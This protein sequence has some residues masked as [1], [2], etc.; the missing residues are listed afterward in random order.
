MP[1]AP[2]QIGPARA[3]AVVQH[4]G[5]PQRRAQEVG[6][7]D[8][9]TLGVSGIDQ[10][11]RAH[12]W[13]AAAGCGGGGGADVGDQALVQQ[14]RLAVEV[15]HSLVVGPGLLLE[16]PVRLHQRRQ[17]PE[18]GPANQQFGLAALGQ[19]LAEVAADVVGEVGEPRRRRGQQRG[20]Q[21]PKRP[22]VRGLVAAPEHP[23]RLLAAPARAAEDDSAPRAV[24][25]VE[26]LLGDPAVEPAVVPGGL[27]AAAPVR[28][29][30]V[31][32]EVVALAV[33][34]LDPLDAELEHLARLPL[35]PLARIG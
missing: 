15:E 11:E 24:D 22:E 3:G 17:R 10:A 19:A 20:E 29:A 1:L 34:G 21:R 25:L 23:R 30:G 33:V 5:D 18:L 31:G 32:R 28:E 35:P 27:G 4:R 12:R 26:R 2:R 14:H 6:V 16:A 13:Q 9:P 7:G 8:T